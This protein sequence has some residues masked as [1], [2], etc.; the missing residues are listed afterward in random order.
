M[1]RRSKEC[2]PANYIYT[3][4]TYRQN[5]KSASFSGRKET[6]SEEAQEDANSS[7]LALYA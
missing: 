4:F 2:R 5:R 3:S 1:R 7:G 6:E